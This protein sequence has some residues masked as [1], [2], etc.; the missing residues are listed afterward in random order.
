MQNHDDLISQIKMAPLAHNLKFKAQLKEHLIARAEINYAS[1][2]LS[3]FPWFRRFKFAF[4]LFLLAVFLSSLLFSSSPQ[5]Q[6]NLLRSFIQEAQ[7]HSLN[8]DNQIYHAHVKMERRAFFETDVF[9]GWHLLDSSEKNLWISPNKDLREEMVWTEFNGPNENGDFDEVDKQ[10]TS[11]LKKDAYGNIVHYSS[12]NIIG[13]ER[14]E[15][16][17]SNE[18][19]DLAVYDIHPLKKAD[20]DALENKF[21]NR[22]TCVNKESGEDFDAYAWAHLDATT[23][24]LEEVLGRG[25]TRDSN[26]IIGKELLKASTGQVSAQ[27]IFSLL[28]K[29]QDNPLMTYEVQNHDGQEEVAISFLRSDFNFT[30]SPEKEYLQNHSSQ[31]ERFTLYFDPKTYQLK[32]VDNEILYDGIAMEKSSMS[33]LSSDYLDPSIYPDLFQVHETFVMSSQL[34]DRFEQEIENFESTCYQNYQ[35]LSH[36]DVEKWLDVLDSQMDENAKKLWDHPLEKT[37]GYYLDIK[38]K[39]IKKAH[40]LY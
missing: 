17:G 29:V 38:T 27:D 20:F 40:P 16:P 7:A 19:T 34:T 28:E 9:K 8:T 15:I 33:L 36:Q 6:E 30:S 22:I 26:L 13:H 12:Q 11:L 3:S 39:T 32:R 1:S 24:E 5:E 21:L 23:G 14:Q 25:E 2:P 37:I 10:N 18:I 35:K 4:P 31:D